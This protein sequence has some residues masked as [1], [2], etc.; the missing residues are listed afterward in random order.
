[1]TLIFKNLSL[2]AMLVTM[3]FSISSCNSSKSMTNAKEE[4]PVYRVGEDFFEKVPTFPGSLDKYISQNLRC[5]PELIKS[6]SQVKVQ[7]IIEK[8][9]SITNVKI[10]QPTH[11][12]ID[13]E[14]KRF[15]KKMP[16]W[17]PGYR[18]GNPVRSLYVIP[19][20]FRSK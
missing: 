15:V 5:L 17:T 3:L 6:K 14:V 8:D 13:N 7:F 18:D 19:F 16:N 2:Y 9:G 11:S 20:T 10:I 4:D 12:L 1:M